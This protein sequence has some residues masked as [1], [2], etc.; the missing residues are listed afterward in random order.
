MSRY[1]SS[2]AL[3]LFFL[4]GCS[5]KNM[6][7]L[8][9]SQG[10]HQKTEYKSFEFE[11]DYILFAL[12]YKEHKEYAK[13]YTIFKD[14]YDKTSNP[15]YLIE[16]IKLLI[17]MKKYDKAVENLHI[18]AKKDFRKNELYRLLTIVNIRL[19]K[20]NDAL[21]SAKS[22]YMLDPEN[23]RNVDMLASVY[24]LKG[25]SRKAYDIYKKFY[26]K[27]HDDES[28]VKMASILF[29]KLKDRDKTLN[30]LESHSKII[31]CS[32]KICL[33]LAEIYRQENDLDNLAS[34]YSRLYEVTGKSEYA[35]KAAEIYA[36]EKRYK[37]AIEILETSNA[38]KRFLLA[39]LKQSKKYKK[40]LKLAETLY[41]ETLDPIWL[42][43]SGVLLYEAAKDKSDPELLKRVDDT[44]S[45]AFKK[46]VDEAIY[47]NYLGYLL[48]DHDIDL[49]RGMGLVQKAL[50]A[51]PNSPFYLDSLAWGYFKLGKCRKARSIMKK[52]VDKMGL[53]DEE[54]KLHWKKID[55]CRSEKK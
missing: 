8:Y 44:L 10:K 9:N 45:L 14:L 51:A 22:A 31:G 12:Y 36:Y 11:N 2:L 26:E 23:I 15:E 41:E 55:Q 1:L 18:L 49:Q 54:I 7:P 30:L 53:E 29:H 48:I 16:A 46:G 50:K 37:K 3:L 13:A 20:K 38:D 17:A 19:G 43:E 39:V 5:Q 40:A 35:Q 33:F 32:E 25:E 34:I 4:I 52:V 27:H 6:T 24:M 42:A 21:K 47:L 28:L